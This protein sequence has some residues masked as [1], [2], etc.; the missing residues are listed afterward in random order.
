MAKKERNYQNNDIL[1]TRSGFTPDNS[2]LPFHITTNEAENYLQGKV[3]GIVQ[4]MRAAGKNIGDVEVGLF[5]TE[6]GTKFLPFVVSLPTSVLAS[7]GKGRKNANELAIFN[8][9]DE[10]NNHGVD[11]KEEFHN[12]FRIYTY[13]KQD[14]AAFFSQEWR[15]LRGVSRTTSGKIKEM[16]LPKILEF[17]GNQK[18]VTFMLDPVRLFHDMLVIEGDN[19][20]FYIEI[21]HWQ[22]QG[23]GQYRYDIIRK[24]HS[25][26]GKKKYEDNRAAEIN[27]IL[28]G[29]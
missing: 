5:T 9:K 11:L 7:E 25:G 28:K 6:P 23:Q 12:L 27:R 21:E 29:R 18:C 24:I 16:R 10:D 3:N 4:S 26:K 2:N 1:K 20:P 17:S 19:R 8:P 13:N 22:R 14:E 15:R